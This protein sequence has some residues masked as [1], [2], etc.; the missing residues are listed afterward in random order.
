[1]THISIWERIASWAQSQDIPDW[2]SDAFRRIYEKP[3]L[4]QTDIRE[5]GAL[6]RS[7]FAVPIASDNLGSLRAK[8]FRLGGQNDADPTPIPPSSV[9]LVSMGKLMNV[10]AIAS[11]K[12]LEFRPGLT[13]VF[14][15]NGSGK[16]GYSRVLKRACYARDCHVHDEG[17]AILP[18]MRIHGENEK[19]ADGPAAEFVLKVNGNDRTIPWHDKTRIFEQIGLPNSPIA[20]FDSSAADVYII[21]N[22]E[23]PFRPYGLDIMVELAKVCD[24]LRE[25]VNKDIEVAREHL[26]EWWD[27]SWEASASAEVNGFVGRIKNPSLSLK[28][29]DIEKARTI[30]AS[31]SQKERDRLKYLRG[32]F[33]KQDHVKSAGLLR[34]EIG[35]I[36]QWKEGIVDLAERVGE[37]LPLQLRESINGFH[38]A[39]KFAQGEMNKLQV[40]IPQ[41]GSSLWNDLFTA[42]EKFTREIDPNGEFPNVEECVLCQQPMPEPNKKML[43]TLKKFVR[44]GAGKIRDD[45]KAEVESILRKL[46]SMSP[47]HLLDKFPTATIERIDSNVAENFSGLNQEIQKFLGAL[48][49]AKKR[50]L[51]MANRLEWRVLPQLPANP[52]E[53]I[54]T[55]CRLAAQAAVDLE[56]RNKLK[57][58]HENLEAMCVF[59]RH[60]DGI[61]NYINLRRCSQDTDSTKISKKTRELSQEPLNDELTRALKSEIESLGMTTGGKF[62]T[63][64][65]QTKA[66]QRARM[67]FK[68][69]GGNEDGNA[70]SGK[71]LTKV[72]SE[73]EQR[74]IALASFFAEISLS[75]ESVSSIVFDDPVSSLDH[76]RVKYFADRLCKEAKE[77]QVIVFTHDLYFSNLFRERDAFKIAVWE[78][79]DRDS[80]GSVGEMP[81]DGVNIRGKIDQLRN[82]VREIQRSDFAKQENEIRH[83]YEDLRKAV[84]HLVEACLLQKIV[85]R[86]TVEIKVG[87]VSSVFSHCDIKREVANKAEELHD[88]ASKANPRHQQSDERAGNPVN[89]SQFKADIETLD[90]L[91]EELAGCGGND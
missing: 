60:F 40:R 73:G 70:I 67:L 24:I 90:K 59:E 37:G 10:N 68:V 86:R 48:V 72:L 61:V 8:R 29:E 84:E 71:I 20:V 9:Q 4:S 74:T 52:V 30:R 53:K 69:K 54:E 82:K 38:E 51:T 56:N 19:P 45:K 14:G 36:N 21:G 44:V 2:Q 49:E 15:Y 50:L 42:A 63:E 33:A 31:F 23:V 57:P 32:I 17:E 6:L 89:L 85:S 64:S 3:K 41:S 39:D 75:P 34:T 25:S 83:G 28:T 1:M 78:D 66:K 79:S 77:R 26:K 76:A 58:E 81:F 80:F 47:E 88:R 16:T 65:Q 55:L 87:C 18:D 35:Q 12:P 62:H 43:L 91:R 7:D 27:F 46:D 13:I 22:N 5:L 11:D